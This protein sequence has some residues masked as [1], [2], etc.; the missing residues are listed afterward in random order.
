MS[1][2]GGKYHIQKQNFNFA[3]KSMQKGIFLDVCEFYFH[4]TLTVNSKT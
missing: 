1:S 4:D 2:M 3:F